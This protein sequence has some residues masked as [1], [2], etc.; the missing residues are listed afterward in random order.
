MRISISFFFLCIIQCAYDAEHVRKHTHQRHN[1]KSHSRYKTKPNRK[2]TINQCW[3]PLL[4]ML[5]AWQNDLIK[6]MHFCIVSLFFTPFFLISLIMIF[7]LVFANKFRL[8]RNNSKEFCCVAAASNQPLHSL[9]PSKMQRILFPKYLSFFLL[10]FI[11]SF[12]IS[13]AILCYL[14]HQYG[15]SDCYSRG[16]CSSHSNGMQ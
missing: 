11:L 5:D 6:I 16:L 10:L 4:M 9:F 1:T 7:S 3:L 12:D 8:K 14:M 15:T 13:C 2:V